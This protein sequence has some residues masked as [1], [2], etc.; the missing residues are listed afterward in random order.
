MQKKWQRV[1]SAIFMTVM[2]FKEREMLLCSGDNLM[3]RKLLL[4]V[5]FS[6]ITQHGAKDSVIWK[7]THAPNYMI[8]ANIYKNSYTALVN[9]ATL[10]ERTSK[11]RTNMNFESMAVELAGVCIFCPNPVDILLA[12]ERKWTEIEAVASPQKATSLQTGLA[13]CLFLVRDTNWLFH[14]ERANIQ[15]LFLS[16]RIDIGP[17]FILAATTIRALISLKK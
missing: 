17:F 13:W 9:F 6:F 14:A 11:K 15:L 1:S 7:Y 16:Q 12:L 4:G 8:N 10:A 5:G 3:V 2:N